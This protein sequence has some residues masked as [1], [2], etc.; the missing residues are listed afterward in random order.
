VP[1]TDGEIFAGL[2]P[3]L[4]RFAAAVRPVGIDPQDLVQ[5]A[6][7]R[8]LAVRPL[9]E[10]DEPS[11]YL[12]TA[13]VRI[14]SNLQRGRRRAN[15]RLA[16]LQITGETLDGYPSDLADLL[17][18]APRARAIL[19][20]TI[21]DGQ[22]YSAAAMIVGCSEPAARTIASRALRELQRQLVS[23]LDNLEPT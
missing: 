9:S 4:L 6:L 11:T 15:A 10:I 18:V 12:R 5:E 17:R 8:A 14:A 3:S 16:R 23:E 1:V 20:L 22:Q 21:I 13:M 19:F 7:A 2:Y